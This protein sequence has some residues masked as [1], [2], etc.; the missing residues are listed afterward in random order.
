MDEAT[1]LLQTI[2]ERCGSA[3]VVPPEDAAGRVISLSGDRLPAVPLL[4]PGSTEELAFIVRQ[5]HAAGRALVPLGGGTGLASGQLPCTGH[6]WYLSLERMRTIEAIDPVSRIAIVQAGVVL[7]TLQDEAAAR[8]MLFAVDLGARGSA[9]IGGMVSTN[10]GGE[11]VLRFGMMREQ[12]LGLEVVTADGTVLDL[13]DQVL[14]NNAGFDLKQLFIGSEGALGIVTR[15][16]LRLRPAF[17]GRHA[18][19]LALRT[20]QYL[21][22]V[23]SRLES[24]L[25]GTLSAF[26]LMWPEFLRTMSEGDAAPHRMPLTTGAAGYLLVESEGGDPQA[27]QTR[28]ITVLDAMLDDGSIDDAAIAQSETQ[29][30]AFWALRNDAPRIMDTWSPL[31]SFDVS[32]PIAQ[33]VDYVAETRAALSNRWSKARLLAFGHVADN[34]VHM[35]VSL[36]A[37]TFAQYR[38]IADVVYAGV[39]VRHGSISAEHGIGMDKRDALAESRSSQVMVMM[40]QMKQ[41]LD[42]RNLLNPGK[43]V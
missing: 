4:R 38:A 22:A 11:R 35:I 34:N 42:P 21:P 9:T 37:D 36:G 43:V 8:G 30:K 33:M 27:D 20:L 7:Q 16:V 24:G 10:A 14:K 39:L 25:G 19:F 28:L 23:L 17:A 13:M 1:T 3:S 5:A 12:V 2:T 6:E 18:A 15:A 40:R 31:A 41:W 32:V 26:E 29:R